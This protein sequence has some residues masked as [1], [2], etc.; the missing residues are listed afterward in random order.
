MSVALKHS[1]SLWSYNPLPT[2]CVLYLPLWHPSLRGSIFNSVDPFRHTTT[3]TGVTKVSQGLDYDAL[4][5]F[6]N[7]GSDAS[8]DDIFDGGGTALMWLN[9]SSDG[10]GDTG[11]FLHKR[12]SGFGYTINGLEQAVGKIK[13]SF[14]FEFSSQDGIWI[15]TETALTIGKMSL[16]IFDYNADA[17]ANN[18]TL[19][20]GDS[21]GFTT[22]T[23]GSGLTRTQN[24]V[25]TSGTDAAQTLFIGNNNTPNS[26][27]HGIISEVAFYDRSLSAA[28]GQ[29][30][31]DNS[32]PRRFV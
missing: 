10:Q 24:P 15:T 11:R 26:S 16:V 14:R 4:D 20:I 25:G 8:I 6:V 23:V 19:Y 27:F 32:Y 12:A 30:Y 29:Y 2:G 31:F 1:K 5:D 9:P 28:M 18:P 3:L 22:L 7:A 17:T 21:T 13:I